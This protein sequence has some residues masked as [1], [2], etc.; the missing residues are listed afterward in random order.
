MEQV[1]QEAQEETDEQGEVKEQVGSGA[2][3]GS[4]S[5]SENSDKEK[6]VSTLWN[7]QGPEEEDGGTSQPKKKTRI[8][9][10]IIN[11]TSTHSP[12]LKN[13]MACQ[14]WP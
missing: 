7:E 13:R 1:I 4:D 6:D 2:H 14:K 5:D 8:N 12:L 11:S 9:I 3:G 10:L